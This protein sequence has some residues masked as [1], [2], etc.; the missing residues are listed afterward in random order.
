MRASGPL[1]DAPGFRNLASP[2]ATREILTRFDF[3]PRKS[4]GQHFLVDQ[5]V[6]RRIVG[7]ASICDGDIILEVGP[8]IGTLTVALA[9]KAAEVVA[10]ERDLRLEP[11]LAETLG[12]LSNVRIIW[13]DALSVDLRELPAMPNKVVSNLP[14]QIATPL[15]S[16]LV[17]GY[18]E[19][20]LY[21][22]MIQRE[23]G[24]RMLAE[25]GG[26]DYGVFSV[27]LRYFCDVEKVADV[28][29]RVFLPQPEVGSAVIRIKRLPEPRVSVSDPGHLF[30]VVRASFAQ[31]R[32]TIKRALAGALGRAVDEVTAA[33]EEAGIDGERR[34][35]TLSLSEFARLSEALA[36]T[37][38]TA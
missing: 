6:L 19:I 11:V 24:R 16:T 9:E 10:I 28:S 23:V 21:V 35:E 31:R 4:L 37:G 36:R 8:G 5:N 2:R 14:Y 29:A 34:G 3:R 15:I 25:P 32:K 33:L 13:E 20:G 1:R 27:K 30:R 26:K 22:V 7:A 38:T 18:P 12:G 17:E